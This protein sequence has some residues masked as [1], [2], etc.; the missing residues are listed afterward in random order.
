[1]ACQLLQPPPLAGLFA[2]PLEILENVRLD[3]WRCSDAQPN[4]HRNSLLTGNLTGNFAYLARERLNS[5]REAS[6]LQPLLEQ[7]P[8]KTIREYFIS[9]SELPI[10]IKEF[11]LPSRKRLAPRQPAHAELVANR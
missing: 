7:F 1:L 2:N 11:F 9:N 8:A 4:L 3:G 5:V 6:I 10:D